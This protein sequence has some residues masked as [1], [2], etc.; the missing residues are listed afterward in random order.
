MPCRCGMSDNESE[1]SLRT[2]E[3]WIDIRKLVDTS[4]ELL[5]E[6]KRLNRIEMDES[7]AKEAFLKL[8]A[9]KLYGCDEVK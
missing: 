6:P 7:Q 5:V 1:E 3:W 4:I 8:V 2:S 9:H